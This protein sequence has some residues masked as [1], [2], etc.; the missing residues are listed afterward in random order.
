MEAKRVR[1]SVKRLDG[2]EQKGVVIEENTLV[3]QRGKEIRFE[4]IR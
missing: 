2:S 4:D 1:F 3:I